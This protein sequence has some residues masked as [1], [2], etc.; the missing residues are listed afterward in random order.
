MGQGSFLLDSGA[1]I[2]IIKYGKLKSNTLCNEDNKVMLKG[3]DCQ[4]NLIATKGY[5]YFEVGIDHHPYRHTFHAVDDNFPIQYDGILGNDFLKIFSAKICYKTNQLFVGNESTPLNHII[6]Q[7]KV[8]PQPISNLQVLKQFV[9]SPRSETIVPIQIINPEIGEGVVEKIT[10]LEGVYMCPSIVRVNA[11]GIALTSILNTTER[12][13]L[14]KELKI[15]LDPLINHG[16]NMVNSHEST[17]RSERLNKITQLLRTSHLNSEERIQITE[18]CHEFNHIF[19]LEGDALTATSTV[20]HEIL[21]TSEIPIHAKTYRFPEIHKEEVNKQIQ[22][23]LEQDIIAPSKSPWNAP[24]WVVPKKQDA[25]GKNKWRIVIDYRRLNDISIGDSY[26]IPNVSEI[27]DQL[28]HS[29]Y[30]TILDLKSGFHQIPLDENSMEKTSFSVPQGHYHFKR[31][32]MGL[33]TSPATFQR[34][35]NNVLLGLQN[36]SCF[37]Y[38]DDIIL[39]SDNLENHIKNLRA[40]FTRLSEHNLK[41]EPD[42]CEFLRREVMY[43]GHVISE[44]G[45]KPDPNKVKAVQEFPVPTNQTEIKSLLGISG[46]YRRFIKDFSL[47]TK[48]LTKL[49]KKGTPFL[50]TS[51]QQNAFELLKEKLC[52][53]PILQYP[54]FSKPFV[55]TTDASNYAIGSVLSNG[56]DDLPISYASRTLNKAECNYSTIEKELLSIVWSIRHYRPYLYGRKFIIR[57]D[58]KPLTYLFSINDPGSRLMRWRLKLEEYEYEIQY[59]SGKSNTNADTLSRLRTNPNPVEIRPVKANV[60]SYSDFQRKFQSTIIPNSNVTEFDESLFSQTDNLASCISS[61]VEMS[62]GIAL[63]FRNRF[64]HEERIKSQNPQ[65]HEIVAIK[66]NDKFIYY[67]VTKRNFWDKPSYDDLFK[68]VVLLREHLIKNDQKSICI[69]RLGCGLDHLK[70]SKVR[71]MIRYIFMNTQIEVKIYH[72]KITNP[73]KEDIEVILK[74]NHSNPTAGHTG[75]HRTYSRIKRNYKWSNMKKDIK[76]FIKH[77]ESCQKNKLVRKKN[78]QPMQITTTSEKALDK[79][80]LD[81]VGPLSLTEA[82]NRYV[83]TLQDDLT[84]FSQAYAIATHDATTIAKILV[85]NFFLK[86]G[87][88]LSIHTDQGKD[89][90]SN[91]LKEVSKLFKIKQIQSTAYHPESLGALERSHSTLADY[92]KHYIDEEQ[93]TWDEWIDFAMFS[94]NTT[95]HSSTKFTPHELMFGAEPTLPSALRKP[96]EFKYTYDNYVDELTLKLQKSRQIA[97]ENAIKSKERNK[98]YYDKRITSTNFKKGDNV[99]LL[100][101]QTKPGKS[102]KLTKRYLGPYLVVDASNVN[103]TLLINRKRVTVHKNRL[104]LA[105]VAGS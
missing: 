21:T 22:G 65:V 16:I 44:F 62:K 97:R 88:P 81:I 39:Y 59:K 101:E 18:L 85:N 45:V 56:S 76:N 83:L 50:W 67:L 95:T 8:N 25:S 68:V 105:F 86:F 7:L 29:K 28:G 90:C 78:H 31:L 23:M 55:L 63:E 40:V 35:M 98:I 84:K 60:D 104:K 79:I 33:K 80:F 30:F 32:P 19:H 12:P 5:C 61:D 36:S 57:S 34:L 77:C 99:Y 1:D 87:I 73:S 14:V 17:S 69:P 13:V 38:L 72:N 100:N 82:G 92:L 15:N 2:S 102:K 6:T 42:K 51:L 93:A 47:I 74:E 70:W 43:L 9:I 26:P 75:F 24:V 103:C 46:Y 94:Y 41:I 71:S 89:F 58:H 53:K 11:N 48:P 66:E 27:L 54:D 49:L 10:L 20:K 37:V 52:S 3:I 91:L 96:P 4:D 64:K